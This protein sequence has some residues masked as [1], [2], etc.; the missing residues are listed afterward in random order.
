MPFL[1]RHHVVHIRD[2]E[3]GIFLQELADALRK[4]LP[5]AA[6][7]QHL[8]HGDHRG[9][10]HADQ[11]RATLI[12]H[13]LLELHAITSTAEILRGLACSIRPLNQGGTK[14]LSPGFAGHE[15]PSE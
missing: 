9:P 13:L 14:V 5:R 11:L 6:D 8:F 4:N 3:V 10:A 7:A 15:A 1:E 2:L 12:R